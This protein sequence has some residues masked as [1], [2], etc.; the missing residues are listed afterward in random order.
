MLLSKDDSDM[1]QLE[2]TGEMS[3]EEVVNLIMDTISTIST[4]LNH[5]NFW[6]IILLEDV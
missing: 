5:T 6:N 3:R 1:L 4:R 2:V